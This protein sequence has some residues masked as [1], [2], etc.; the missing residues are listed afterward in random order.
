[1]STIEEQL[2]KLRE[3]TLASLKK[4]STENEKE[5]QNLRVSVLGKK[6]SLT[7]ILKGMKDVS[8]DMRPI[9]GKHVNEVRDILTA[10]FE[11]SAKL[12]E[13]QKITNQLANESVDVTLPGRKIPAGNRHVLSQTSEEI[14]DIFIGMGYQVVDGFEVETDYYNFERMNLPK[15]HPARDM[16]DTFY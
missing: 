9:I 11:E 3:E 6:G 15:D 16:Q 2:N 8:A 10:A 7:E 12:L 1:M 14:E 5:M 4:I 13:E